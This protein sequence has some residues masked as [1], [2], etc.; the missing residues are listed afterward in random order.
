MP[1]LS[2]KN[3]TALG[4]LAHPGDVDPGA[5]IPIATVAV[6]VGGQ[7]SIS[8]TSIPS[9]YQ[10]L[11]VRCIGRTNRSATGGDYALIVVNSDASPSSYSMHQL[12]GNTSSALVGAYPQT[13]AGAL[14]S[15]WG[16]ASDGSGT[17]GAGI[18]DILDYSNTNKYKTIR[19]IGG[20][21][22]NSANSQ[23]NLESNLW[24][25]TSA[26]SSLAI[27]PGAGTSWSQYSHFALYGIKRAGA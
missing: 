27:S 26:I 21:D 4:S 15:R 23:V 14:V 17:F 12:L 19:S 3:K 7:S 6:G 11:Q 16:A 8:F 22:T 2:L 18:I 10:H 20:L 24:M 25:N 1:I 9:V 5:M 13:F